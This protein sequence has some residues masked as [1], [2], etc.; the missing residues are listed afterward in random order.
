MSVFAKEPF[1]SAL[2]N[3]YKNLP[4]GHFISLV[5][6][7][8]TQS[9]AIFRTEG[10]GEPLCREATLAGLQ[11]H[12]IIDRIVITKRKQTAVERRSGRELL[13]DNGVYEKLS[14]LLNTQAPCGE[15]PD[16]Y[17]YGYAVGSGGAQRSRVLTE[18]AFSL[19]DAT[20]ITAERTFNALF[21]N[22]TMRNPAT[23]E[24]STSLGSTEYVRPG[25]HFLDIETL[26][27]V[28]QTEFIYVLGNILSS[29]RYGAIGTRIGRIDNRLLGIAIGR[30]EIFSTLELT[31]KTF[32]FL[33]SRQHPLESNDVVAAATKA[34]GELLN[35]V[36]GW[37]GYW[38]SGDQLTPVLAEAA[39]EYKNPQKLVA[40]LQNCYLTK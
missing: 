22:S 31:Q 18:D 6:L 30:Q 37:N 15:C 3:S 7:R 28:T 12:E 36:F 13:R 40:N 8:T 32:D 19:L 9:E 2:L 38:L 29:S 17:I 25:V 4:H 35:Q 10:S 26:K 21:D 24:A 39:E 20:E 23:G 1:T 5:L 14:C 34:A 11:V 27:D 33:P 16:C